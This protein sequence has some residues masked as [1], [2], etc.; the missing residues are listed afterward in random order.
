MLSSQVMEKTWCM[1]VVQKE[2]LLCLQR[3]L[4][5]SSCVK[6][7][8]TFLVM[9]HSNIGQNISIS[10]VL[11]MPSRMDSMYN[12]CFFFFHAKTKNA[13]LQCFSVSWI[14]VLNIEHLNLDFEYAAHEAARHFW[15]D[16]TIK[17]VNFI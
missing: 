13:I 8:Y 2:R 6:M 9:E 3:N 16:V 1:L 15:P 12:V 14:F 11:F 7:M 10:Y 17:G 5:Y 4:T